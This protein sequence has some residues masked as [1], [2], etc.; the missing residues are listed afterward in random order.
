MGCVQVHYCNA[1]R[2][3]HPGCTWNLSIA[4]MVCI[5]VCTTGLLQYTWKLSI[6][7]MVCIRPGRTYSCSITVIVC[8]AVMVHVQHALL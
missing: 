4:V 2:T 3:C 6:T 5:M 8:I 7:E 1:P